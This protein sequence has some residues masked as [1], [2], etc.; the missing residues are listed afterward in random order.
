MKHWMFNCQRVAEKVS[1]SLDGVLPLH[2]R[3]MI[4]FHTLMCSYCATFRR[5]LR[6][7]SKAG[8]YENSSAKSEPML[9]EQA[10]ERMIKALKDK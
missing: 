1:A 5:Q 2:H 3:M 7:M 9:S 6:L 10:R 4:R 8:R